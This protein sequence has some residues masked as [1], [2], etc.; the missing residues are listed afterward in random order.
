MFS[1]GIVWRPV[2]YK[3]LFGTGAP[4]ELRAQFKVVKLSNSTL[5]D[6]EIKSRVIRAINEFFDVS[7]WDFGDTFYYT[8]LS[9]FI[10]QRL[11]GSIASIVLVPLS[12]EGSFG[13]GFEIRCRSDELF[14]STAQ[15]SDVVIINSNTAAN[16]RIR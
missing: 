4:Q 7:Y 2:Q 9:G 16:L 13:E 14:I 6:G 8:E 3:F 10:H 5:S 11:A 1:D 15:V 12:G